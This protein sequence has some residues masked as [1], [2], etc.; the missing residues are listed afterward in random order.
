V[1]DEVLARHRHYGPLPDGATV[2]RELRLTQI[3]A[4]TGICATADELRD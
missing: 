3:E 1:R 4:A 2:Q